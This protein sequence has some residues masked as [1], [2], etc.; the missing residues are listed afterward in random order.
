MVITL[1]DEAAA[2]ARAL[3]AARGRPIEQVIS[4]LL[5][6][7]PLEEAPGAALVRL[8]RQHPVGAPSGWRFDRE[9]C[10][11]RDT[12]RLSTDRRGGLRRYHGQR[13]RTAPQDLSRESP[14]W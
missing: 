8:A 2:R 1:P 14:V 7:A 3:A 6:Q 12:D 11:D 9:A 10:H 4:E 13:L 5:E